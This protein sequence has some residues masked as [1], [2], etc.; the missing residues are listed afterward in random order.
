MN[1]IENELDKLDIP[2]VLQ[3]DFWSMAKEN[4]SKRPDLEVLW[5]LCVDGAKPIIAP[6]D[7]DF[8]SVCKELIPETPRDQKSWSSWTAA[9]KSK[10]GRSGKNLFLPLRKALTGKESGPDMN[11]LFP[12]LQRILF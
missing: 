3:L 6:Q 11:K 10:T 8:I 9:I 5:R 7:S 2:K 4:V 12:L 1:E